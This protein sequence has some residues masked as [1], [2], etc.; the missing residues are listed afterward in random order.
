MDYFNSSTMQ[1]VLLISIP[2]YN[3]KRGLKINEII[4]RAHSNFPIYD[5]GF[6]NSRRSKAWIFFV[7][8]ANIYSEITMATGHN[9]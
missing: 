5:T 3:L 4:G 9:L 8:T 2:V 1:K 7:C 6:T